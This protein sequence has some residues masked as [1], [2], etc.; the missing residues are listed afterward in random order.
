MEKIYINCLQETTDEQFNS[1]HTE[2]L[3]FEEFE[4]LKKVMEILI[5]KRRNDDG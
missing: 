1:M 5:M 4:V 3:T 2:V